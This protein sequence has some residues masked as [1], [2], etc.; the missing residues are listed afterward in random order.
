MA[1]CVIQSQFFVYKAL[2]LAVGEARQME[3]D[4]LKELK[5]S[6]ETKAITEKLEAFVMSAHEDGAISAKEAHS[7]LH[8]MHHQIA[9]CLQNIQDLHEGIVRG[10][11]NNRYSQAMEG[12]H[13]APDHKGT[14]LS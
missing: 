3:T 4:L 1:R 11:D 5:W 12:M 7:I 9:E 6:Y 13:H 2:T 10:P 14:D 8:P